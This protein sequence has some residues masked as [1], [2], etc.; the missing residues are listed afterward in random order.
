MTGTI[1][2]GKRV[3]VR[4]STNNHSYIHGD[5]DR[6]GVANID[7]N[8]PFS[9]QKN[10]NRVEPE[11][12]LSE[13]FK[14][15][16]GKRAAAEKVGK[17]LQ[18]EHQVRD[19][20]VKSVY[21]TVNKMVR[22]YPFVTNDFIGLRTE[23]PTRTEARAKWHSYNRRVRAPEKKRPSYVEYEQRDNKYRSNARTDNPYRA[24]HT[25]KIIDGFGVEYQS[26]T[27][28]FGKLN[29]DM[30]NAYKERRMVGDK[31]FLRRSKSLIAQGF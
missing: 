9:K 26:R 8:R 29:D 11:V 4:R 18:R 31:R 1:A 17:R 21:S 3:L 14:Y 16:E 7:D 30:H 6:D 20:R 28:R 12:R 10:R 24:Y 2:R 22:R 13:T 19:M 5:Y 27:N 15:L 23:A 25:N